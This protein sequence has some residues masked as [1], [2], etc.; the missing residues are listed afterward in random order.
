MLWIT[1]IDYI[2][3][4]IVQFQLL[5]VSQLLSLCRYVLTLFLIVFLSIDLKYL[6]H[7][8][9]VQG[10]IMQFITGR[11][12]FLTPPIWFAYMF[13]T[14]LDLS[15]RTIHLPDLFLSINLFAIKLWVMPIVL[16]HCYL[17][18]WIYLLTARSSL[19]ILFLNIHLTNG[20]NLMIELLLILL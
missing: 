1:Y 15:I 4:N 13:S 17:K 6:D 3:L 18:Y 7:N 16:F 14:S 5:Q 2:L 9:P 12:A 10:W 8:R 11:L 19:L 20:Y